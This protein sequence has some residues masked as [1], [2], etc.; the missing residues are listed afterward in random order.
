MNRLQIAAA[1]VGAVVFTVF[2][3][4][5]GNITQ[6]TTYLADAGYSPTHVATCQVRLSPECVAIATD[7]GFPLRTYERVR[8]PVS[9]A[10]LA[11]GGRDVQLPPLPLSA[12]RRCVEVV[13]WNDC[14]LVTAASAPA[15][16]ALWGQLVPFTTL[17]TVKRCV[18]AKFD[19]GLA[20]NR[21]QADG[22]AYSFG[23]RNVFQ[24]L[25]AVAPATCEPV[26]C[27]PVVLGEDPEAEL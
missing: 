17:G 11:D 18:R 8:F 24:R 27:G 23:D 7:A 19:A 15:I 26:E 20:C 25:D 14:N 6:Q 21:L 22:G 4:V 9:M 10:T 3:V 12:A 1:S 13:D 5:G 16:A 2:V